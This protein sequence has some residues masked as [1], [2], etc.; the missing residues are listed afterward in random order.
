MVYANQPVDVYLSPS[1]QDWNFG[2]GT[3]GTEEFR[4]NLIADVVQYDLER[5][6]LNVVRNSPQQTLT[7]VVNESNSYAPAVHVAIHSNA[8]ASH[9]S[10]G[11]SVYVHRFGLANATRLANDIYDQLIAIAPTDGLGVIE[12]KDA[13]GGKGYYELRRTNAPAVLIEVAFHDQ[14]A[15]AQYIIDN[16]VEIGIAISKG[17]LEYFG[18]PYN[19]DTPENIAYLQSKYNGVYLQ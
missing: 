8:S 15:D 12:G 14:P 1:V 3:Y 5:H 17:I 18:I 11:P 13:F 19:P 7:Q 6:G 10:R 16:I 2:Y 9:Q 4:M